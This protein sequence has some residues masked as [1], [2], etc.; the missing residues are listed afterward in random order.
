MEVKKEIK[1]KSIKKTGFQKD[2][3]MNKKF[4]SIIK[5]FKLKIIMNHK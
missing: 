1:K 3:N 2:K 5:N 4:R